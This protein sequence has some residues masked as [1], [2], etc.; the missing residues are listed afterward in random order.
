MPKTLPFASLAVTAAAAALAIASGDPERRPSLAESQVFTLTASGVVV[1]G[2]LP[3]RAGTFAARAGGS[4][5]GFCPEEPRLAN[6]METSTYVVVPG[7]VQSEEAAAILRAPDNHYPIEIIKL[8]IGWSSQFGGND[9]SL[10]DALLIYAGSALSGVGAAQFV[11]DSPSLLDGG[12]NEFDITTPDS[13]P[14]ESRI[15]N[16]G[17]F[18]VS[19]RMFNRSSGVPNAPA[20]IHD[21]RGC[22]PGKSAVRAAPTYSWF[23]NCSLGVRGQ[24]VIYAKYRRVE[25][26]EDPPCPGDFNGDGFIN[27]VDLAQVLA[28]W[29]GGGI[30]DINRDGFVNA[31]D[32]ALLLGAWGPCPAG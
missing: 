5:R 8:G 10:E 7:F 25:C 6:F 26:S 15:I 29:N 4:A 2:G 19:V 20:P 3:V 31:A 32:L 21:N 18:T 1:N 22:V 13:Q 12:I 9:P 23:D 24:W 17:P 11:A 14:G 28:S 27:S 30:A 16:D